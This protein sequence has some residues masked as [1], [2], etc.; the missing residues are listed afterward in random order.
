V[1]VYTSIAGYILDRFS[2]SATVIHGAVVYPRMAYLVIVGFC[3]AM[4]V[5]SFCTAC[6]I[7]ETHGIPSFASD[8]RQK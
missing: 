1:A 3:I 6:S 7:K 5:I 2:G 4:L 8:T